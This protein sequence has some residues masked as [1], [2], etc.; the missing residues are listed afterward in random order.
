MDAQERTQ[1]KKQQINWF[2][3]SEDSGLCPGTFLWK[4]QFPWRT[5]IF[6]IRCAA[7]FCTA[8]LLKNQNS[9]R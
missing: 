1:A 3:G 4:L 5:C 9:V 8:N 2:P 7:L 6:I